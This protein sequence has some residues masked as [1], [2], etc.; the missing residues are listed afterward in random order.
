MRR[1]EAAPEKARERKSMPVA[2]ANGIHINYQIEGEGHPLLMVAGLGAD[3][4]IWNRQVP[5][6]S[7]HYK[8]IRFDNRGVGKSDKPVGEYSTK[9]MADDAVGLLDALGID[10]AIV[11]GISM[12][13][14]IA[15]EISITHPQRVSK[16]IL[17]CTYAC[18]N[19]ESGN[20]D[21][22]K[23]LLT[24]SG[25]RFSWGFMFLICNSRLL[26]LIFF[27]LS[28]IKA[29]KDTKAA[30]KSQL[31]ACLKHSALDRLDLITAPTLVIFGTNDRLIRPSSS[32]LIASRIPNAKLAKIADGSHMMFMESAPAFNSEVLSFLSQ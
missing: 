9:I 30:Y 27:V 7:K 6:L 26:S 21:K 10:K 29:T 23:K 18:Q 16:L 14:M 2:K 1:M 28:V 24:L 17:A 25:L 3:L 15:Q 31:V 5:V 11:L 4:S 12:G 20:S 32:E 22:A 13:G 19:R 8:L